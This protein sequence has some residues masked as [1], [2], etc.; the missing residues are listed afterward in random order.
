[1]KAQ[2]QALVYAQQESLKVRLLSLAQRFIVDPPD[3][4]HE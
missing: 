2:E 3:A 1:M 4:C